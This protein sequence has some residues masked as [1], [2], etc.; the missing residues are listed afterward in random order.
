MHLKPS[1][2]KYFLLN[3]VDLNAIKALADK[4]ME[5]YFK[6]FKEW[7]DKKKLEDGIN[8]KESPKRNHNEDDPDDRIKRFPRFAMNEY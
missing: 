6:Q 2:V 3:Y 8:N 4:S 7:E 1:D 5:H